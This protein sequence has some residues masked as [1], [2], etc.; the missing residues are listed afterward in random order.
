MSPKLNLTLIHLLSVEGYNF[1]VKSG[2]TNTPTELLIEQLSKIDRDTGGNIQN[3]S[4]SLSFVDDSISN[5]K[6]R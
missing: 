4:R 2:L 3:E 6:T 5:K 1:G